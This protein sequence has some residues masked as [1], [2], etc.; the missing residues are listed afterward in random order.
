MIERED[1]MIE[2]RGDSRRKPR[3]FHSIVYFLRAGG[4][5]GRLNRSSFERLRLAVCLAISLCTID[6]LTF[7]MDT[8]CRMSMTPCSIKIPRGVRGP[9]SLCLVL[10]RQTLNPI[11]E[12]NTLSTTHTNQS[13]AP[14]WMILRTIVLWK[15]IFFSL[16]QVVTWRN[17]CYF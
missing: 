16:I 11:P 17:D 1:P 12:D 13:T 4:G 15:I 3:D 6:A 14:L 7:T 5:E 8:P 9:F 10:V 2:S